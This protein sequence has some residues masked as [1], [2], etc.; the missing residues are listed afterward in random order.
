[1]FEI[2]TVAFF[3]YRY[4]D[5][6]TKVENLL[7]EQIRKRIGENEYVDFLVGPAVSSVLMAVPSEVHRAVILGTLRL[8]HESM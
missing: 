6:I 2:Y 4:I 5:N 1:M 8:L 7:E 3:G